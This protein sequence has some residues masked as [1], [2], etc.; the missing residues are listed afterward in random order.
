M[1]YRDPNGNLSGMYPYCRM[2]TIRTNGFMTTAHYITN[3]ASEIGCSRISTRVDENDGAFGTADQEMNVIRHDP[4]NIIY[5]SYSSTAQEL[6]N[7]SARY[8][9][10]SLDPSTDDPTKERSIGSMWDTMGKKAFTE[11]FRSEID[12]LTK[13]HRC[14]RRHAG[15]V[16]K[17][18]P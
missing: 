6:L 7:S 2:H 3:A 16:T 14:Q 5:L 9:A 1:T 4:R 15:T 13:I 18:D 10:S 8:G 17:S 11:A 12:V